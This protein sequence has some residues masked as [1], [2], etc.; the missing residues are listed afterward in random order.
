VIRAALGAALV[1]A[2]RRAIN[3]S[4][5]TLSTVLVAARALGNRHLA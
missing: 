4:S 3:R 5:R 2:P 1:L